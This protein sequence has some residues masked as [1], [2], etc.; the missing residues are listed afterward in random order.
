[1]ADESAAMLDILRAALT[2]DDLRTIRNRIKDP[3]DAV[4]WEMIG[5]LV[6]WLMEQWSDF[7]TKSPSGSSGSP[8]NTGT[9]STGRVH[10]PGSIR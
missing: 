10:G 6:L 8:A 2:D 1:M 3:D 4:D 7:P 9:T 5:E